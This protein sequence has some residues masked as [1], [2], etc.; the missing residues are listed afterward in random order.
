MQ[1]DGLNTPEAVTS[2]L[3]FLGCQR[4]ILCCLP[5]AAP[6]RASTPRGARRGETIYSLYLSTCAAPHG[7]EAAGGRAAIHYKSGLLS[8]AG[9]LLHAQRGK[10]L[11]IHYAMLSPHTYSAAPHRPSPIRLWQ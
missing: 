2:A 6:A 5:S 10:Q 7:E 9:R 8:Q 1:R 4:H 11:Y 3:Q